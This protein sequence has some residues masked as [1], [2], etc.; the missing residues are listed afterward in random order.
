MNAAQERREDQSFL[1][2][3]V[4]DKVGLI[5]VALA[6]VFGM[7]FAL[8]SVG[9]LLGFNATTLFLSSIS[10]TVLSMGT[11]LYPQQPTTESQL[12]YVPLALIPI[13][14]RALL[15]GGLFRFLQSSLQSADVTGLAQI[16]YIFEVIGLWILVAVSEEGF[17]ATVM[18][19][20]SKLLPDRWQYSHLVS[21]NILKGFISV[22]AWVWFHFYQRDFNL[23]AQL[24]YIAWLFLAGVVF[25]YTMEEASF[26]AAVHQHNIVNLTA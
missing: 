1:G 12:R 24:P 2:A 21:S 18:M 7:M 16:G 13:G 5:L 14:A 26:G 20:T 8:S 4:N 9:Y 3:T 10:F 15:N 19:I 23:G 17:R 11:I 25:T 22:T 6:C